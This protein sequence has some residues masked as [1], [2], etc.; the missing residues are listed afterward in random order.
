VIFPTIEGLGGPAVRRVDSGVARWAE[1][2]RKKLL[3]TGHTE[4]DEARGRKHT[5]CPTTFFS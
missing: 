5:Q 4:E 3:S 2:R 1:R